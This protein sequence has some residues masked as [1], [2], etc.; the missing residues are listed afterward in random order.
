MASIK[1]IKNNYGL[2]TIQER[3][4]LFQQAVYNRDE[5]EMSKIIAESPQRHLTAPDFCEMP[6]R[7]YRQDTVNLLSR[8]NHCHT[9]GYFIDAAVKTKNK[10]E[11]DTFS[12][13]VSMSAYLY[14]IETDAWQIVCDELGLD[15]RDFREITALM[16]L[17][18]KMMNIKDKFIR[19]C[20]FAEDKASK[21]LNELCD[22]PGVSYKVITIKDKIKFYR[23]NIEPL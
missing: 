17:P 6:E 20:A 16:C 1:T 15:A 21:F 19:D 8:L 23:E 4:S 7:V 18:V 14:T 11:C 10:K 22:E 5:N 3:F 12:Q 2:L 13:A 9:F